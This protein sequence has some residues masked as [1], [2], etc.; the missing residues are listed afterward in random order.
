[1]SHDYPVST[2]VDD[3]DDHDSAVD[4][5]NELE[6]MMEDTFGYMARTSD[7]DSIRCHVE[8]DEC[9]ANLSK[10]TKE[11][12]A[13][14]DSGADTTILG[15]EWLV[16]AQDPVRRDNLVGFD[17]R[18]AWK[19]GLAIVTADTIVATETGNEIIIRAK[20]I[21]VLWTS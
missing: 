15:K 11:A 6:H 4:Q 10:M 18:H 21:T 7:Q 13:T 14:A 2:Y 1:V 16:I 12:Y 20:Q 17:P 8:Y 19:Q 5:M 9:L 3:E